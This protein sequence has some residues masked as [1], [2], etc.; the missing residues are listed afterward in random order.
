MAAADQERNRNSI[1]FNFK[2]EDASDRRRISFE[3]Y[4]ESE[5]PSTSDSKLWALE[6]FV[7]PGFSKTLQILTQVARDP[8]ANELLQ[9]LPS[10]GS[11]PEK[12]GH[13]GFGWAQS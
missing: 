2:S 10:A 11:S 3:V 12:L 9:A 4:L 6:K 7:V 1:Y 13:P 5:V 8:E